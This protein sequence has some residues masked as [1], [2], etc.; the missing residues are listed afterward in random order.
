M[1]VASWKEV[2]YDLSPKKKKKMQK[3]P[4]IYNSQCNRLSTWFKRWKIFKQAKVK[5]GARYVKIVTK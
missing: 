2:I 4:G 3:P 5:L 1:K